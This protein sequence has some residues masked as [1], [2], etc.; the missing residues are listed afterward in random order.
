LGKKRSAEICA[1]I[2][3]AKK[4]K[5]KLPSTVPKSARQFRA[6]RAPPRHVQKLARRRMARSVDRKN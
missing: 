4:G 2:R 5:K 6:R 3:K 1:I